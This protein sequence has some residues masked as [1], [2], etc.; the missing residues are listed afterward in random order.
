MTEVVLYTV[1]SYTEVCCRV[2]MARLRLLKAREAGCD[3]E[4]AAS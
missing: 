3:R 1:Q 2:L 4:E